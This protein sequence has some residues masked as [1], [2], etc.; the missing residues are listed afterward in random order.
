MLLKGSC[1]IGCSLKQLSD[2]E[3]YNPKNEPLDS[4]GEYFVN[5]VTI[6]VVINIALC[7][8]ELF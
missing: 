6:Y 2:E 4:V 3:L 5:M 7:Q 1:K 8:R